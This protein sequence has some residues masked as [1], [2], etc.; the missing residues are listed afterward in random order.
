MKLN[1]DKCVMLTVGAENPGNKY[2]LNDCLLQHVNSQKHS[3]GDRRYPVTKYLQNKAA[4]MNILTTIKIG[5]TRCSIEKKIYLQKCY[6]WSYDHATEDCNGPDQSILCFKCGKEAHQAKNCEENDERC[7]VCNEEG[8]EPG[9]VASVRAEG[10][11]GITILSKILRQYIN[12]QPDDVRLGEGVHIISSRSENDARAYGD[13]S[14]LLG[15]VENYLESHEVRIRLTELMPGEGFGRAFKTAMDEVENGT[16]NDDQSTGRGG[17]GGGGGGGKGGGGGGNGGGG[18]MM[19]GLMMGKL[20][21]ALG[22]GGVGLLAMKALMVSALALMLSII[23]GLKKLVHHDDD[24][25]GHHVIHASH[26]GHEYHR[27]KREASEIAYQ[28][29]DNYKPQ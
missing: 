15:A 21:A 1:A 19:M 29:W 23:I 8:H 18:V 27:K 3:E 9:T 17:G 14:T 13:D 22:I 26:G 5:Y 25:G 16:E 10:P 6:R 7:L 11:H 20:L 24:G 2:I 4:A 12:S 28:G